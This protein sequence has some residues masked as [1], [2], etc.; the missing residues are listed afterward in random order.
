M[1]TIFKF[2]S[3]RILIH[4][5]LL[6]PFVKLFLGINIFGKMNIHHLDRFVLIANHNSHT[7]TLLLFYILPISKIKLTHPVAAKE[8]F[9]KS[10]IVFHLV[11]F[12][13]SPI[14]VERGQYYSKSDPLKEIKEKIEIGHS[15]I[16]FPEG[17]RGSAG[18]IGHFQSGIGRLAGLYP[19]IP[20]VP[21]YLLGPE[22]IL[23]KG[24][25]LPLP[26][27]VEVHI[28]PPQIYHGKPKN[29][30]HILEETILAFKASIY[31]TR[32]K[33]EAHIRHKAITIAFLGIDG[34]GKST[35]SR[36]ISEL[37]S[38]NATVCLLGDDILLYENGRFKNIQPLYT[39]EFRKK[40]GNYAKKAA[41]LKS[42]KI[43]KLAELLLRD[44]LLDEVNRWYHPDF[45]VMDGAPLLNL[46]AWSI[47]YKEQYVTEEICSKAI[48]ILTSK[49]GSVNKNDPIF[50]QFHELVSLKHFKLN[51]LTL[52]EKVV[53][54][55]VDPAI[56]CQRIEKRGEIKQ[57]HET[58][59]KLSKLRQAYHMVCR[60][61]QEDWT[62]HVGVISGN[63]S[64]ENVI[65]RAFAFIHSDCSQ[66]N[67]HGSQKD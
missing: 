56:A 44:Y 29:I 31:K 66:D 10:K 24:S 25:F 60:V 32:Q 9:S 63:E 54:I 38:K 47:L 16:I 26:F 14:W 35:V 65:E 41:S 8:Y 64:L 27:C 67:K 50:K 61:I 11:N 21:V 48:G 46:T 45:I 42:Y 23:P 40:I 49:N 57:V 51:H 13:F 34:S 6:R 3:L 52:P 18:E 62:I 20:I 5:F 43:P 37:I 33:R 19:D 59:E 15:V 58:E 1:N 53:F 7:D 30:S 39:N 4:L 2:F 55:D 36:H 28:A 12:L 17:T 22:R